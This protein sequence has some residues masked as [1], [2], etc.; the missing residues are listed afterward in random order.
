M[1]QRAPPAARAHWERVR[2]ALATPSVQIALVLCA[3]SLLRLAWVLT[4]RWEPLPD[5]DAYRYDFTAR[6]LADGLGYVH[7]D[8]HPTAFWPP[9]YSLLVSA[10]YVV[11][12]QHVLAAQLLNVALGTATAGLVYLLGRQIAGHTPAVVAAGLTACWPSLVLFTGVTLSETAFT[13]FAL[14]SLWLLVKSVRSG[15]ASVAGLLVTGAVFGF[16]ALVR[17]QA[18]LLPLVALP[19]LAASGLRPTVIARTLAITVVGMAAIV[20]PWTVRNAVELDAPVLI[21]TNAGVDFWIGHHERANGAFGDEGGDPLV[22]SH[23]ELDPVEREVRAN[24]D[25]FRKGVRYAVTH[26][27][28][29]L[30]LPV[31]KLFWL[32]YNDEEGLKWNEGHGGQ[33]FLPSGVRQALYALS[34]VYYFSVLALAALGVQRWLVLRDPGRVLLVSLVVYWTLVHLVFFGDA[35]FHTPILPI[36][37]LLAAMAWFPTRSD[38][39][40]EAQTDT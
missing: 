18:L 2:A 36:I 4:T 7:L 5:D 33:E 23:P 30:V 17:G 28:R 20:L 13:F 8:G 34:N 40:I 37:G 9:G 11:F 27:A 26:P 19:Y 16:A 12:G 35:R 3:A 32:Y 31:K 38:R 22:F 10:L 15:A 1:E 6:A 39:R 14:L 21:S 29:E 25:G 24:S